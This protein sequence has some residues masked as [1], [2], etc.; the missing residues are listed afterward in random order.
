MTQ[1][2]NL[3][4]G[5]TNFNSTGNLSLTTGV[6]GILPAANGGTGTT[7]STG[8]G[9]V[10]LATSPTIT[11]PT[12]N[13]INTSVANTSLG[14]GNAS[15]MKNRIINGAVTISQRNGSSA[16]TIPAYTNT[17]GPDRWYGAS[18][19]VGSKYSIAQGN[20]GGAALAAGFVN[21]LNVVSL[22]AYSITSGD[23]HTV[24]Q[25]VE[26]YNTADLQWGTANAKTVTLSFW[27]YSSITG[28]WAGVITDSANAYTYPFTYTIS[29]A[30]TWEYKTITIAGP[31]SG[32]WSTTTGIGLNLCFSVGVGSSFTGTA[33][34]WTSAAN[35]F[36]V[37]GANS[38]LGTNGAQLSFTGVQLEVGSNA[39]GFEY[40]QYGTELSLCQRYYYVNVSGA[41]DLVICPSYYLN[42]S[43]VGGI[44]SYPV[45]MRTTPS[46]VAT[47]GSNYYQTSSQT[48]LTSL[49]NAYGTNQTMLV[50][51]NTQAS[52]T[53]GYAGHLRTQNASASVAFSA[54]L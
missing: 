47:S 18:Q 4:K 51:N 31:T 46:L 5:G 39:T 24:C 48:G 20:T 8:S 19:P 38:L 22:S 53:A 54:E 52:G 45:T 34:A 49:S 28:T 10:V 32:T 13:Q 25:R 23:I 16:T 17:Y 29:S 9:A 42:S 21:C 1:A 11:T 35:T 15:I 14:A 26:G 12:I 3:A 27:A 44:I 36:G 37:T 50:F 30:S 41:A 7:S 40:R 6:T 43:N 2:S 33:N